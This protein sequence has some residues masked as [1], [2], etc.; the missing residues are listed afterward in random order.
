MEA[1]MEDDEGQE[2]WEGK[3][4]FLRKHMDKLINGRYD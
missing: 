4:V 3:I 2:E 1:F